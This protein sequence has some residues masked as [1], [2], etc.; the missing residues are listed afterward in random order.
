M[1]LILMIVIGPIACFCR[2]RVA[3]ITREITQLTT[4]TKWG[5]KNYRKTV[6]LRI[7]LETHSS[8]VQGQI[9]TR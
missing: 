6:S 2:A 1:S 9:T 8:L 3:V 4:E 5:H 7:L